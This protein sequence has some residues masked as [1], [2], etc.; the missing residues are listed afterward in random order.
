MT[1][2]SKKIR[3]IIIFLEELQYI[4]L[5]YLVSFSQK[6]I[7]CELVD[8]KLIVIVEVLGPR[9]HYLC[10]YW[11]WGPIRECEVIRGRVNIARRVRVGK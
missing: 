10:I 9:A 4:Y 7:S 2:A 11:V 5:K 6:K 8:E 3:L 1:K